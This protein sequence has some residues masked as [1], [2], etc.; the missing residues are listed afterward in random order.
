[1]STAADKAETAQAELKV[2]PTYAPA[3]LSMGVMFLAWGILTHWTL[4]LVGAGLC[5]WALW[6]WMNEITLEWELGDES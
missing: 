5:V 2:R 1:M 6:S 4:S 3:A